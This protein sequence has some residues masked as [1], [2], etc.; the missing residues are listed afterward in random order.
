M[1][2][3]EADNTIDATPTEALKF[4]PMRIQYKPMSEDD[5]QTMMNVKVAF[6]AIWKQIDE[7]GHSRELALSKTKLEEACMW[8]VKH[9]TA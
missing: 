4:D 9:I 5:K 2:P 1:H 8:A 7:L 6:H 3:D